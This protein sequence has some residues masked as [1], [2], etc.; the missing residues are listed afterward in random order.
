MLANNGRAMYHV[1]VDPNADAIERHAAEELVQY[2]T[3][4][5]GAK[6]ALSTEDSKGPTLVVGNHD[7]TK[8]LMPDL[9][10]QQLGD[11]GF[12]IRNVK[13][14]VVIAGNSSRGTMYGVNYFLDYYVGVKWFSPTYTYIPDIRKLNLTIGNDVQVPR[15]QYREMFVNDDNNEQFRAHNLLNGKYGDRPQQS[16]PELDS[17]S[18]FWPY[19][20]HNFFSI[21][22][23]PALHS[24]GQLLAMNEDV[25]QIAAT[26]L[27]AIIKEKAAAGKDPSFGF[28][29]MDSFWKPDPQ[30]KAF[31]DL[32]GGTLS[33]PILD[34]V[35][36]VANR[37]KQEIPN[38][39]I[40]TLVYQFSY[41]P[42]TGMTIPDN[43]VIT[44][45]PIEKDLGQPINSERNREFGDGLKQW[46][47]MSDNI[48]VWD[49]LTNFGDAGHFLPF[50][51]LD[52]M[53]ETIQYLAQFPAVK[54][55]FG[56]HMGSIDS[57]KSSELADLRAWVGAR[58]LWNPNQDYK[59]LINQF[60][61]GFYGDAAPYISR[62][63]DLIHK[64]RDETH[65]FLGP[66]MKMVA[67]YLNFETMREADKLFE[68]A[69]AAVANNP[70]L[71]EHVQKVRISV[72]YVILAK[73]AEF[74]KEAENRNIAWNFD[75]SARMQRFKDY[76]ADAV[77]YAEPP[78]ATIESLYKLLELERV[79]PP[80]PD[81]VKDLP[82]SSW[83]D[84]QE[85]SFQLSGA[86]MVYDAKASNHVTASIG[87]DVDSWGIQLQRDFLP[88][89][90]KWK[91]YANVRIDPGTGV[92]GNTAFTYGIYNGSSEWSEHEV[93][94]ETV[95][96]GEY[97]FIEI[98]EVFEYNPSLPMQV[99]YFYPPQ[100]S[101]IKTL[102]VDQII[103]IR[104]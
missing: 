94:Y 76:T 66:S 18:Q 93:A 40:G 67:P 100:S 99:L 90:G 39:R 9:A 29:Q 56:Q 85:D 63:I 32:H 60:V 43:V 52:A 75:I 69:A 78:H 14:Y 62:Y 59:A 42:P 5:T 98:A 104:Q 73:R 70:V 65:S 33:A 46:A 15:F 51:N 83:K 57:P 38:A 28:G 17:W 61:T 97:H 91:L 22:P 64:S 35:S 23:D 79:D 103:A 34:M 31:A 80:T 49:Y 96:D 68:Q 71:L 50:P 95:A 47:E 6:F 88:P 21:V 4:V 48:V 53:S 8:R 26:N 20:T 74:K 16:I 77:R 86:H 27:I 12:V 89:E 3:K 87:G 41:Q 45:A 13:H 2:L 19:N 72:D 58:L 82:L 30:S 1:Y 7:L 84:V 92:A 24:G 36:D 11:D 81:I 44:V 55:Y 25:R 101:V 10:E 102:N 54:G 37:V